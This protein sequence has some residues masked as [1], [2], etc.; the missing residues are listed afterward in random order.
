MAA[1]NGPAPPNGLAA[2]L[3]ATVQANDF[4]VAQTLLQSA[5]PDELLTLDLIAFWRHFRKARF[6]DGEI[7]IAPLI[8][9]KYGD[10]AQAL[11]VLADIKL[12]QG[13]HE[14]AGSLIERALILAENATHFKSLFDLLNR[15]KDARLHE[16]SLDAF[17]ANTALPENLALDIGLNAASICVRSGLRHVAVS[18]LRH[19]KER[20]GNSP[21][22][23]ALIAAQFDM[24]GETSMALW[25]WDTLCQTDPDNVQYTLSAIVSG[26]KIEPARNRQRLDELTASLPASYDNAATWMQISNG[27]IVLR[28]FGKAAEAAKRALA[29]GA[30]ELQARRRMA[31]CYADDGNVQAA[32]VELERLLSRRENG[33]NTLNYALYVAEKINDL[34]IAQKCNELMLAP[35]RFTPEALQKDCP[36]R[37]DWALLADRAGKIPDPVLELQI[38]ELGIARYPYD[39][40]LVTRRKIALAKSALLGLGRRTTPEAEHHKPPGLM[41]TIRKWIS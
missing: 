11:L 9:A 35:G 5:D 14:Q 41:Q 6:L 28:Q 20:Y 2:K 37:A 32:R 18:C 25:C 33:I 39:E 13:M 4:R 7:H 21:V 1:E 8:E 23:L 12:E 38:L 34:E 3:I 16:K 40:D 30:D 26:A 15:M 24:A 17:L 31:G 19:L 10:D 29:L 22:S 36:N 27:H